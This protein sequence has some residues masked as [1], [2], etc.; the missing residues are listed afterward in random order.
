M[1]EEPKVYWKELNQKTLSTYRNMNV[2]SVKPIDCSYGDY[3]NH[4]RK[5]TWFFITT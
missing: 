3:L 1:Y 2:L 5:N 4:C